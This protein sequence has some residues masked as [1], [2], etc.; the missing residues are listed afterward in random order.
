[1]ST[2]TWR[3]PL[4][5]ARREAW[6][7]K[8]RS[9]LIIALIGLPVFVLAGADVAFR[10]F[11]LDPTE[12]I[13][14]E[15]GAADA[16]IRWQGGGVVEQGPNAWRS[17]LA[18]VAPSEDQAL[19][20]IAQVTGKFPV[21]SRAVERVDGPEVRIR[22]EAGSKRTDLLG[23]EYADPIAGNL[24]EQVQGR[25]PRTT[26][27]V[28]LTV[29]LAKASGLSVGGVLHVEG[30]SRELA[31]VGLVRETAHRRVQRGYVLPGSFRSL[32]DEPQGLRTSWLV[33]TPQAVSWPQVRELNSEGFAVL[34]RSVY[35]DPPP[36]SEWPESLRYSNSLG[37]S[38]TTFT[39]IAGMALL[40][41][42]LLAGPA[43]AVS[44]RRQRRDLALIAAVG[45]RRR[46][47]RNVVLA[48]G[49]VLGLVAGVLAAVGAI[50][51][52]AVAIPALASRLSE[53]PGRFDVRPIEVGGLALISLLTSVLAAVVPA[54]GAARTDVTA[55]LTGRSGASR[56]RRR[57]P[58]LGVLVA[59]LGMAI[60]LGGFTTMTSVN[61]ILAGIALTEVGLILCT[62]ALLG[63]IARLGRWLP[64]PP[65][66]ALR[67]AGRNRSSAAPAVA[68]VMASMIGA[69]SILLAVT[70][71]NDREQRNYKP[72]LPSSASY[73]ELKTRNLGAHEQVT[74]AA[75]EASLKAALPA[76]G[77]F[78]VQAPRDPCQLQAMSQ[79]TESCTST[80]IGLAPLPR[81]ERRPRYRGGEFPEVLIDDGSGVGALFGVPAP[82]AAAALRSGRA[83]VTDASVVRDGKVGLAFRSYTLN[84]TPEE[85]AALDKHQ[86]P[87]VIQ[88]PAVVV[89]RG[90]PAANVILPPALAANYG[91]SE[92]IGVL[93]STPA[94][95]TERETQAAESAL[96][97]LDPNLE[98]KRE[99]GY[100][101]TKAWMLWALV[102]AAAV[103]AVGAA[104]IATALANVDRRPDLVTLGSI[105][106]SPRTRRLLSMS[107]A[108]VIAGIGCVLGVAAGFVPA[109]AWIQ[110]TRGPSFGQVYVL[111]LVVPWLLLA[112]AAIGVPLVSALLAGLFSRSRLPSERPAN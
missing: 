13:A 101:N 17:G 52:V 35:L 73:V 5:I 102:G 95:P 78:T 24:V 28:A 46:D 25:T 37:S 91:P 82:E 29:A 1:M 93:V 83:V 67:D 112:A 96:L 56:G 86:E 64:V 48:H 97:H 107:R 23:L 42:V 38:V 22:T 94:V 62:P 100:R 88:V 39:L 76:S 51:V 16:E 55:T 89:E 68:A 36:K 19:P 70:S 54:H 61:A 15:I 50:G 14:R 18:L 72:R 69:V 57:T 109:L 49:V 103:V 8:G 6:R 47:L 65:R 32:F 43:F 10:T 53:T 26:G 30:A 111:R 80:V 85:L 74:P 45:G 2:S 60:A 75:V 3:A 66:I 92:V 31:I 33:D 108:G 104:S 9:L 40:E 99:T 63:L 71:R 98:L 34:S 59:G 87:Q 27:E 79:G 20:D 58:V 110:A 81:R 21:G 4:R 84:P 11:Q 77:F 12:N 41:V 105:G 106:A 7:A 44:A 90:F